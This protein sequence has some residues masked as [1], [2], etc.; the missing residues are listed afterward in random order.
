M[1]AIVDLTLSSDES[2]GEVAVVSLPP[3][4]RVKS[5]SGGSW[6]CS[7]CTLSNGGS[8]PSCSACGAPKPLV[9][10]GKGKGKA[11]AEEEDSDDEV[12]V[13]DADE[14]EEE[15]EEGFG[16]GEDDE[17]E[18]VG[19]TGA[20]A[21]SDYPHSR[22]TCV[23]FPFSSSQNKEANKKACPNCYCYVCDK[24]YTECEEWEESHCMATNNEQYWVQKR[25]IK[26][27]KS[28]ANLLPLPHYL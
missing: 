14:M 17:L 26:S 11:A 23:R 8:R 1:A 18:V 13:V 20:N 28:A 4:K 12:M 3:P 25:A 19:H 10:G 2:D 5:E 22:H 9:V 15:M 27:G 21:M 24:V 6:L 7:I 16:A